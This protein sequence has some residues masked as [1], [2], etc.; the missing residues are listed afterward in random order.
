[1][2]KVFYAF[3]L[4]LAQ[5]AVH[6]QENTTIP[7]GVVKGP[8]VWKSNIYPGTERNYWVHVPQQYD[9]GKPASLM[10]VQDGIGRAE[11]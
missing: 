1:M 8:F 11:G 5:L 4:L 9:A 7:K 2:K 3:I 10:V 6:A